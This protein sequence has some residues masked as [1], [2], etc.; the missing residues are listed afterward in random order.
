MILFSYEPKDKKTRSAAKVVA[1]E[2]L[3]V[4]RVQIHF[5]KTGKEGSCIHGRNTG[6]A[7]VTDTPTRRWNRPEMILVNAF[8][9]EEYGIESVPSPRNP[10]WKE[11]ITSPKVATSFA[12]RHT[13]LVQASANI[14]KTKELLVGVRKLIKGKQIARSDDGDVCLGFDD[15][16]DQYL[17]VGDEENAVEVCIQPVDEEW[18]KM[19]LFASYHPRMADLDKC[20]HE[21]PF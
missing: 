5:L 8:V 1:C 4:S 6:V 17:L 10:P 9:V 19:L 14:A 20:V 7:I 11:P 13:P 16:L 18:I 2:K 12:S 15:I 21:T 3:S